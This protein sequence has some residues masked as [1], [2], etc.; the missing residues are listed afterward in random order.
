MQDLKFENKPEH[1]QTTFSTATEQD[2]FFDLRI[3]VKGFHQ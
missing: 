2:N 3:G 1:Q